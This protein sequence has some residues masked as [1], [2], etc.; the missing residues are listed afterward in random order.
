[1]LERGPRSET[2]RAAYVE[3]ALGRVERQLGDSAAADT[4]QRNA[5]RILNEAEADERRRERRA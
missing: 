2:P 1:V 4:A 5:R 3:R